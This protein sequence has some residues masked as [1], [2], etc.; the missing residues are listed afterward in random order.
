MRICLTSEW[1]ARNPAVSFLGSKIQHCSLA[2][3][4]VKSQGQ[5]FRIQLLNLHLNR[6]CPDLREEL[7]SVACLLQPM[8]LDFSPFLFAHFLWS[9]NKNGITPVP[10]RCM[11]VHLGNVIGQQNNI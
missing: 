8:K 9:F 5:V 6:V 4:K 2:S 7:F 10:C 11:V 3:I 1:A